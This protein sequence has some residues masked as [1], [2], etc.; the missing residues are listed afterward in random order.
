MGWSGWSRR[1]DSKQPWWS[2]EIVK[3]G[4]IHMHGHDQRPAKHKLT[5]SRPLPPRLSCVSFRV[6]C[7]VKSLALLT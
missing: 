4:G 2:R 6:L 1:S 7:N 5:S 3:G